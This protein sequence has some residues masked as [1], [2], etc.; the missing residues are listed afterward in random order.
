MKVTF[1]SPKHCS[2]VVVSVGGLTQI[3]LSLASTI[4]SSVTESL[5]QALEAAVI[6]LLNARYS[7]MVV[8]VGSEHPLGGY[9]LPVNAGCQSSEVFWRH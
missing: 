5:L 9:R 2:S 4:M 3:E 7:D 8:T 1:K 6:T